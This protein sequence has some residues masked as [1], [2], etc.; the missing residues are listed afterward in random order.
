MNK[1][2]D[3]L[4]SFYE[5]T[6][7]VNIAISLLPFLVGGVSAFF[8]VFCTFGFCVSIAVKELKQT[9]YVFYYNNGLNKLQLIGSSFILNIF[10]GL[11]LITFK[12]L[13]D[14]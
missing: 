4:W 3:N 12:V 5:S 14:G 2:T 11:I 9:Q 10:F 13:I 7:L 8:S 6:L 1:R